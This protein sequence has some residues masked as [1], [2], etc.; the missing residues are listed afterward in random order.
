M[1]QRRTVLLSS[2]HEFGWAELRQVLRTLEGVHLVGEA[3]TA[4]AVWRLASEFRPDL[5]IAAATLEGIAALP[6]LSELHRRVCPTSRIVV[7]ASRLSPDELMLLDDAS[8]DGYLLWSDLSLDLL[9]QCLS[10]MVTSDVILRSREV[11]QAFIDAQRGGLEGREIR[12]SCSERELVVLKRLR[13]GLNMQEIAAVEPMSVRTVQRIVAD[14]H[15]KLDAPSLFQLGHKA[16][17]FGLL[18]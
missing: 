13:E 1:I 9:G 8:I 5:I 3:T 2:S 16:I 18:D 4:N 11:A 6:L 7:F 15:V 12:A 17:R 14:L 10:L